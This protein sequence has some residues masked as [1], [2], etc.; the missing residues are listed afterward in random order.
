MS[1]YVTG[2][3]TTITENTLLSLLVTRQRLFSPFDGTNSS[4]EALDLLVDSCVRRLQSVELLASLLALPDRSLHVTQHVRMRQQRATLTQVAVLTL[5]RHPGPLQ[6]TLRR[7][8][9]RR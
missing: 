3:R 5:Q 2:K 9:L 4:A 8:F 7:A 6:R 1:I